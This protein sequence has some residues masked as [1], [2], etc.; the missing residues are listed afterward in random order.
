MDSGQGAMRKPQGR[1]SK[2]G[3]RFA[4]V[5]E[6]RRRRAAGRR[7]RSIFSFVGVMRDV[8][9]VFKVSSLKLRTSDFLS[10]ELVSDDVVSLAVLRSHRERWVNR[11]VL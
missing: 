5:A 11:P 3:A 6:E 1:L 4:A 7:W 8:L 10:E 9:N 2:L